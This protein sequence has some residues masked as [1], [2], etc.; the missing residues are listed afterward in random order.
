MTNVLLRKSFL[1]KLLAVVV[2]VALMLT[3]APF[4]DIANFAL[5][6]NAEAPVFDET[7]GRIEESG[8]TLKAVAGNGAGFRGWYLKD[9][10]EVSYSDTITIES[11]KTKDDYV[12]VFY[13]FNLN[14]N[15]SF[16]NEL[17]DNDKWY[18]YGQSQTLEA[19]VKEE[20]AKTG[21]KAIRAKAPG[22]TTYHEFKNIVPNTQYTISFSYYIPPVSGSNY[23]EFVSVL[24]EDMTLTEKAN[25]DGEYLTAKQFDKS[26]GACASG[27][28][29]D[30]SITFCSAQNES[31]KLALR[32]ISSNNAY[33]YIDDVSL[34]E[35]IVA[36]PGSYFNEDFTLSSKTWK[37][38]K[39]EETTLSL[40]DGALQVTVNDYSAPI[41]Y[42]A[43][44]MVKEGASYTLSF[45]LDL[46]SLS[47][48]DHM[49]IFLSTTPG[50]TAGRYSY[51]KSLYTWT[52][53]KKKYSWSS[54]YTD[55]V[56]SNVGSFITIKSNAYNSSSYN[57]GKTT[58]SVTFTA[59]ET[60]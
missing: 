60:N 32:Y 12:P 20:Y 52:V 48:T 25:S 17:T 33:I 36:E 39:T 44:F 7:L 6:A 24:G 26:T 5:T 14:E 49:Q 50:S 29:N 22:Y 56:I 2:T 57:N 13:N 16:E 10:T 42:S 59:H 40:S 53:K 15:A 37:A 27:V 47:T 54:T 31:V 58:M 11:G 19:S 28:W 18:L 21:T 23:L 46:S 55:E 9:G 38:V 34:V 4:A 45:N 35:D 1:V 3:V 41:V 43:P 30:V 51:D 8:S